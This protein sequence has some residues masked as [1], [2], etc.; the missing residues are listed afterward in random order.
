MLS[1]ACDAVLA[2]ARRLNVVLQSDDEITE[3]AS[4]VVASIDAKIEA[5]RQSG[6]LKPVNKKYKNYRREAKERGEPA[7]RYDEWMLKY[8]ENLVR[9]PR[10]RC[11]TC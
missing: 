2:A 7:M 6:E 8:R 3:E 11:A 9:R 5:A 4:R 1:R 10:V